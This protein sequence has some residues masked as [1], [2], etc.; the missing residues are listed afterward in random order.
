MLV[1]FFVFGCP[2]SG[3][4]TAARCVEMIVRD[5]GEEWSTFRIND[6]KIL[7]GWFHDD[8]EHTK[9]RPRE[10]GG[11]DILVPELY[12]EALQVLKCKVQEYEP[13]KENEFIII[14]FARCD[15][16]SALEQ[17]GREFMQGAYFLFLEAD[18][19]TCVQR[20][21]ERVHKPV[22]TLDDHFTSEFVFECYRQRYKDFIAHN[23]CTLKTMYRV[24]EQNIRIVDNSAACSN[25]DLYNEMS[26]FVDHIISNQASEKNTG[27]LNLAPEH[28]L[29]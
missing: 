10:Y 11:F 28:V 29:I 27:A 2:G 5:K 1:P 8:I 17:F 13:S 15:Y 12:D 20:I 23:T 26:D 14:E 3:K 22:R 19:E 9:F 25:Q 24:D 21:F 4:S 16:Q 18:I 7:D 6:Y